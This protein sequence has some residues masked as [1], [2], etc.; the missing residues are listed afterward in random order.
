MSLSDRFGLVGPQ[1]EAYRVL[2]SNLAVSLSDLERPTVIVT[3]ARAG[4]GKTAT[5]VNLATSMA[6]AGRRVVLVD[7]DLRHADLH[8]WLGCHNEFGVSDAILDQRSPTECLQYVEV[9]EGPTGGP[10]GLYF[11][12]TGRSVADP[13]ELLGTQRTSQLLHALVGEADVV[14]IDTPPVLLV[15]DTL[16]IGR[17][18]AGAVLVVEA[19]RTP[20]GLANQAK[21]SLIRN[22]TRLLGVVLNKFQAKDAPD[23]G[24][25]Y[26]YGYGY[27]PSSGTTGHSEGEIPST[28][29]T[30]G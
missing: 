17:M 6:M 19:G 7:L 4:E 22:Q 15:A 27:E 1:A 30:D 29:L 25:G 5:T 8:R 20:A 23:F 16:V 9:G 12:A 18:V 21:D 24:Y 3:S 14:L 13:A 2:R 10:R 26:G 28:V 11:L